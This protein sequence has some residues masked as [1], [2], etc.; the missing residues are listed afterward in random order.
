MARSS[1]VL[2]SLTPDQEA[3]LPLIRDKWIAIGLS[4]DPADRARAEAGIRLAYRRAGLTEPDKTIWLGSPMAGAIGYAYLR[5]LQST[6]Q[7]SVWAS[8]RDSVRDSVGA[9]V[10]ASVWASVRD[11]VGASVWDSVRDS[12]GASV[13]DSASVW[14]SV[15]DSVRDAGYGQHDANW[16]GF[17]DTFREFGLHEQTE[18]LDGLRELT[19]SSGWYWP[20]K[21]LCILTDRPAHLERDERGRLHSPTRAA[22]EYRDGWGIFSWHGLRVSEQLILHPELITA[23]QIRDEANSEIRRV[24]LERFGADRFI[25]DIGA[26]PIHADETGTL[27]KV[28]LPDD[29]PLVMVSLVNSTPEAAHADGLIQAPD[30]SWR[31]AYW[32][33]VPPTMQT[34]REA[35]AW[36]FDQR[37][38]RYRPAVET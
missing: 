34:A 8:V 24:M 33:R 25:H 20:F 5:A 31:K 30:G 22:L 14:A 19:E 11:S 28:D 2:S 35:V 7:A 26:M 12:V 6:E 37:A 36:T 4:T 13:W 21:G 17:Y 16:I 9:S 1:I 27:Y 29:E 3:R 15:R 10:G 18:K 38:D 23:L 32:L